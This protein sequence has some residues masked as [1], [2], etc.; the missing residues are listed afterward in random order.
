MEYYDEF[1]PNDPQDFDDSKHELDNIKSVDRGYNKIY[2]LVNGRMRKIDVYTTS[3]YNG[4]NI[5]DA[6][7]GDYM[8]H[9]VGTTDE[10]LYFKVSLATGECKSLNA[11]NT[12]FYLSPDH[13]E[14]HQKVDLDPNIK[15]IWE[16]K[17]NNYLRLLKQ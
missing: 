10:N 5:R 14:R 4:S 12:L 11:S 6:E 3:Y 7:S 15:A 16:T 1:N 17:N 8:K 9:I 2:R 13:F